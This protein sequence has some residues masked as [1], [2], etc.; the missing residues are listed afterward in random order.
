M[1][2]KE[3]KEDKKSWVDMPYLWTGTFNIV[4]KTISQGYLQCN[5]YQ[6]ANGIFHRT[7]TKKS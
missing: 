4:K 6:I 1:L 7:R 3:G 2:M 5:L